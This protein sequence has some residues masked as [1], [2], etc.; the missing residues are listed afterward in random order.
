MADELAQSRVLLPYLQRADELQKHDPRIAYYCRLYAM[1]KGMK[2]PKRSKATNELLIAVMNQLELDKKKVQP[3]EDDNLHLEGFAVNVFTKADN[4]DRAGKADLSTAKTFY[5]ASIFLEVLQQ[6]GPLSPDLEQKRKY[7]IF[8]AADIRAAI[9]AGKT[10]TPG[11]PGGEDASEGDDPLDLPTVPSSHSSQPPSEHTS[12]R[13]SFSEPP[14]LPPP[15]APRAPT[16]PPPPP[17]GRA[18]MPPGPFPFPPATPPQ[19]DELPSIRPSA[20]FNDNGEDVHTHNTQQPTL[21]PSTPPA[22]SMPPSVPP[23][24]MPPS[25]I[26]PPPTGPSQF[27]PSYHHQEPPSYTAPGGGTFRAFPPPSGMSSGYPSMPPS[28]MAPPSMP[29]TMPPL[30]PPTRTTA[31]YASA[32]SMPAPSLPVKTALLSGQKPSPAAIAE[33]QK[34]ARFAVSS[35]SFDDVASAVDYLQKA[36][37]HLTTAAT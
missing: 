21:R 14:A 7:A 11:P 5:A 34:A 16:P 9:K 37:Q 10:P 33:A 12:R 32:P 26:T 15:A 36:L 13:T 30:M 8:K 35:L 24:F 28:S 27:P 25:S 2:I 19:D 3:R 20:P 22:P 31:H 18:P 4:Q 29:P 23:P 17:A 1:E 6:F